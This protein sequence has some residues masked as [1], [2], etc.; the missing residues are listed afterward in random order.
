MHGRSHSSKQTVHGTGM[1]ASRDQFHP[2]QRYSTGPPPL[3][4]KGIDPKNDPVTNSYQKVAEW[5]VSGGDQGSQS[6]YRYEQEYSETASEHSLSDSTQI[7][8]RSEP[9]HNRPR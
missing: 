2:V 9:I 1:A 7:S 5:D 4:P 6:D 8:G 3:P